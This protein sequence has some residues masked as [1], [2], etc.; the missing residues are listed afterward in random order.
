MKLE[1][2]RISNDNVAALLEQ[3]LAAIRAGDLGIDL[4]AVTEC[5]TA[6]VAMLLAWQREARAHG[7]SLQITGVPANLKSLAQ[8]YGVETM[9]SGTS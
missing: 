6:A 2:A 7:S 1:S 5:N 4:S 8:L 3:G 9:I